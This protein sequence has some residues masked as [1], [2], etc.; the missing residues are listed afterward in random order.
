ML[1]VTEKEKKQVDVSIK[2]SKATYDELREHCDKY[3]IK[4]K[5]FIEFAIKN[6]LYNKQRNK[7]KNNE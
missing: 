4:Y 3:G 7:E 1:R 6:Y 2:I 5:I